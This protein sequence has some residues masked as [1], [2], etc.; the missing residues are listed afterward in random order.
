M[1]GA[2]NRAQE[3]KNY[4][5][6]WITPWPH[7]NKIN[8]AFGN[9]FIL[10]VSAST[11]DSRCPACITEDENALT[12]D[13]DPTPFV[14]QDWGNKYTFWWSN[15]PFDLIN[16][17]LEKAYQEMQLGN[18]GVMLVPSNQET[19]WY[20]NLIVARNLPTLVYPSRIQFID[21]DRKPDEKRRGGNPVGTVIVSFTKLNKLPSVAGEPWRTNVLF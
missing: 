19:K 4:K 11:Q 3:H 17:F 21:P 1:T 15:P 20:R 9:S 12:R 13:W 18:H 7:F 2:R 14:P 8:E 10:D 16:D 6:T 5:N